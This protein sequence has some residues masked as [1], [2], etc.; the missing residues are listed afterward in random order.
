MVGQILLN[1]ALSLPLS[2]VAGTFSYTPAQEAYKNIFF[3]PSQ[4]MTAIMFLAVGL[5]ALVL[6]AIYVVKKVSE[7]KKTT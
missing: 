7:K 1:T 3:N 2:T 5:I 4:N 6:L